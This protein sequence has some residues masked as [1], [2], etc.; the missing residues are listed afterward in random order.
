MTLASFKKRSILAGKQ[1][2]LAEKDAKLDETA[3]AILFHFNDKFKYSTNLNLFKV[4]YYIYF[5]IHEK[6]NI[7]T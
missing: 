4:E 7:K 5:H 1:G 2:I 3:S 6:L